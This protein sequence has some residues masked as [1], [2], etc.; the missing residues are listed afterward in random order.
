LVSL[1]AHCALCVRDR[2]GCSVERRF[3]VG[4]REGLLLLGGL[5]LRYRRIARD[6]VILF[7]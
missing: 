2:C 6:N 5:T 7:A 4:S 3:A 1:P